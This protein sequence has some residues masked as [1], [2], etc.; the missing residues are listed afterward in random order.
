MPAKSRLK[1][2]LKQALLKKHVKFNDISKPKKYLKYIPL[3]IFSLPFY[4][5]IYYILRNVY[6][7]D[8]ANIPVFNSYLGLL[9]PFF[10]ANA[11]SI[12]YIFLNS[13]KGFDISLFLTLMLFLKLQ[14]FIFEYWWFI[15]IV[16]VFVIYEKFSNSI[17]Q[18]KRSRN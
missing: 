3:L 10:I 17:E 13:K 7:Q 4:I 1:P 5:L 11:F 16:I 6:P 8:I 2:E 15:P 9:V 14:H 18:K 12:S